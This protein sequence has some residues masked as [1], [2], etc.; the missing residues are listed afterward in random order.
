[1]K[2]GINMLLWSGDVAGEE[3]Q[4]IFELGRRSSA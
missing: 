3:Y 1:M 2:V 4:S